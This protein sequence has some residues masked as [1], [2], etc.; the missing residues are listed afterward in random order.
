MP[1]ISELT[2][3]AQIE[4]DTGNGFSVAVSSKLVAVVHYLE[5]IQSPKPESYVP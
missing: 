4:F 2:E 5:S 1:A 3:G